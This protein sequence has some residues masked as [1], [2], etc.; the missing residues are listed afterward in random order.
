M[1]GADEAQRL[2]PAQG[3]AALLEVKA[4]GRIVQRPRQAHAHAA[5]RVD[6]VHQAAE[7]DSHEVIDPQA[8]CV[9]H[10]LGQ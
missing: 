1:T 4:G 9:L 7:P 6:H 5:D 8:G 10:R 2:R 3:L